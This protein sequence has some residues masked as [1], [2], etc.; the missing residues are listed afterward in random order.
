ML[1]LVGIVRHHHLDNG[2]DYFTAQQG[3]CQG[4]PPASSSDMSSTAAYSGPPDGPGTVYG[5]VTNHSASTVES[6]QVKWEALTGQSS[7]S[8]GTPIYGSASFSGPIASGGT[9]TWS[10]S[11]S[12]GTAPISNPKVT[13]IKW[14][15]ASHYQG[16]TGEVMFDYFY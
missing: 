9:A 1:R 16:C 3:E 4:C 8:Y 15:Y 12:R 11:W 5:T 14:T 6:G 2:N 10:S 7:D 13:D